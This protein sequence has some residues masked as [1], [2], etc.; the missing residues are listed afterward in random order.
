MASYTAILALTAVALATILVLEQGISDSLPVAALAV[1]AAFSERANIRLTATTQTSIALLPVVFAAVVFGAAG[2][3]IVAAA[4][5]L[6]DFNPPY[7][8][9]GVYTST[10]AITGALAGFAGALGFALGHSHTTA[11][12]LATA[13]AAVVAESADAAFAAATHRLRGNGRAGNLLRIIGPLVIAAVPMYV[14]VVAVLAV[15]YEEVSA[16]TLP[17]FFVPAVAAQR[18]FILYREQSELSDELR[19]ANDLLERAN[20]SFASALVATL[21][22]RDR[23]TAGHSASVARYAR[24][25]AARMGLSQEEQELAHVCG[26]V[27]DIGKVGLPPGLLEKPGPLTLQE[28]RLMEEHTIIGERILANVDSYSEIAKIVRHHHERVDGNGYPDRLIDNDIPVISRI[29]AVADAYD[30][31]TS[32]RPYRDA[33]PPQVARLRLA[34]AVESQFDT[35]VVAAFEAILA[36]APADYGLPVA[37]PTRERPKVLSTAASV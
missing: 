15:A 20:L 6:A 23:Y 4:S 24:D 17:L 31:M 8:K 13:F 12:V 1:V 33:M 37:R 10:R 9:W 14:P 7:M 35:A 5:L 34:Q 36:G 26:L 16:W 22:A 32:D 21:D 25:I 28:R 18:L 29:L 11:I 19:S 2:A 30:A 3:M 27:H